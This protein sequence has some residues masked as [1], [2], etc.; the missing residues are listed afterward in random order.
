MQFDQLK[1]REFITLLGGATVAWPLAARAQQPDQVRR[2]GAL[3]AYAESDREGRAFVTAFR[4]GLQKLGW[5]EG[6]NIRID[7]RWAAL[8]AELM[9]RF[10]K[11]LVALQPDLILSHST[12]T[13]AA[14][15]QQT[16]TIPIIFAN[17]GDPVGSGFV[18][19]FPRPGG[20]RHRF[21]RLGANAGRQV[22]GTA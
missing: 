22:G 1:R 16:R 18:A 13:T 21:Q 12:P 19:S 2:I 6:R 17:V 10:A 5:A 7:Y 20:K 8:D 11:E 14:L 3:M 9:Q 4:E 15:L